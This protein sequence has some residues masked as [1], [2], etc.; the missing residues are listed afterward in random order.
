[1]RSA[2]EKFTVSCVTR[3]DVAAQLNEMI[4]GAE[5]SLRR[6]RADE[7]D[8]ALAGVAKFKSNDPRLTGGVC[9]R[10]ADA[11]R[12]FRDDEDAVAEI[13]YKL[14]LEAGQRRR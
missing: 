14:A 1:M 9:R 10:F 11:C 5:E 4:A 8:L 12:E 3:G 13:K 7:Y 2:R 6:G